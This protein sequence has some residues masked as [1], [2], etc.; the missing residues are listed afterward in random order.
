VGAWLLMQVADVL[1]PG[2]GLPDAAVNVLFIAAV[3]GFPLALVFGWFFDITAHGIVRTPAA[4]EEG[5]EKPLALQRRDYVILAVLA[6]IGAAILT[7]ATR[8]IVLM[9]DDSP[10]QPTEIEKLPNSIAVLPFTNISGDPDNESFRLGVSLEILNRL[11]SYS[12]LNVIGWNSSFQ[13]KDSDYPLPRKSDLLGAR[14][15]LLG[16]VQQQDDRLRIS[17]NLVDETGAQRWSKNFDRELGDIFAIQIE[18]AQV[19]A[20]TVVPRIVGPARQEY[21][22]SLQAYQ[23]FLEGQELLR[24][25]V[26]FKTRAREQLQKAI[27]LDPEYAAA[28]AELAITYLI[29]TPEPEDFAAA[30]EAIETALRLEPGMPRALAAR[31]LALNQQHPPDYA[32][33]EIVLREV[34]ARDPNMVDAMNWLG[35]ALRGQGKTAQA[36]ELGEMAARRD[37]LNGAIAVNVATKA[38]RRGD[39]VTAERNLLRLL[40]IPQPGFGPYWVLQVLYRHIG[41]LADMNA[42][43]KRQALYTGAY[44]GLIDSYAL[45]GLW[46]QSRYWAER[47]RVDMPDNPW[48]ATTP[49]WVPYYEGRYK[50]SLDQW[51]RM[52]EE[53]GQTLGDRSFMASL[54]YGDTQALSGDFEGAISTLEPEIGPPESIELGEFHWSTLDIL[55]SLVWSYQNVGMPEKARAL[56]EE[57]EEQIEEAQRRRPLNTSN[58]AFF[59]ARNALLLGDIDL[60]LSRLQEAIDAGW[61]DYYIQQHDP[62]W[63]ALADDPRYQAL[64]VEVKADVDRQ[65]AEVMR[66]DEEEDFPAKL[67]AA[68]AL[69]N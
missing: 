6:I 29:G 31:A 21:E 43:A 9:P 50:D 62:R 35:Q 69:R 46:D 33:S 65:R 42:L 57:I 26:G 58:Y 5:R 56:L 67:D 66:M 61:R 7:E 40:E 36:D 37:P 60:A 12:G 15:L 13:L 1:F 25:R 28:Y 44:Y 22:P 51:D 45:L 48:S 23:S 27:E 19:V 38:A 68:R 3:V 54:F 47:Q 30:D 11:G 2:W 20:S 63:S 24:R 41:R 64:M 32:V 34:R 17:A 55:H 59:M 52:L 10:E 4:D 49:A 53:E 8:E 18:I 16:S 39:L 14:Y